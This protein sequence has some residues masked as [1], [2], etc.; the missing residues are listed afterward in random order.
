MQDA[1]DNC[2]FVANDQAD[3]GGINTTTPDGIGDACQCGDVTGNGIVNGQDGNAIQRHGL[4]LE[5]NPL[6][7]NP[8]NCDVTGND[9]CDGQ[10]ANA[11]KRVALG[12]TSPLFGQNCHSALGTAIPP[13]F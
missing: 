4:G 6:F 7:A 1:S 10:D 8:G 9:A 3:S 12:E 13:G 5:P 2:P 11:V